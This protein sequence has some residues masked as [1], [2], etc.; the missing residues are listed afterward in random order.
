MYLN[1]YHIQR[2]R[3]QSVGR[4]GSGGAR[5]RHCCFSQAVAQQFKL[6]ST[7]WNW[8]IQRGCVNGRIAQWA[9]YAVGKMDRYMTTS[10][11]GRRVPYATVRI[12]KQR[13]GEPAS[14]K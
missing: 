4:G 14:L 11:S 7:T 13:H 1:G 3:S 5:R 10:L 12:Y 9:T 2:N 8:R 6:N